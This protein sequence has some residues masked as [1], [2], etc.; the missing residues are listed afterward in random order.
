MLY[1]VDL[2]DYVGLAG[3]ENLD[4]LQAVGEG[5]LKGLE[6]MLR[7]V[8]L[9]CSKTIIG[10]M[11]VAPISGTGNVASDPLEDRFDVR[12]DVRVRVTKAKA[13]VKD[14][15]PKNTR[16]VVRRAKRCTQS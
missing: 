15:D 10:R 5:D 16:K 9:G 1:V 13:K 12:F 8:L 14:E 7:Q 6:K 11:K 2:G 3:P 4:R